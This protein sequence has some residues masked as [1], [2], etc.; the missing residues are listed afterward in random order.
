MKYSALS[1]VFLSL[2]T[3]TGCNNVGLKNSG[4]GPSVSERGSDTF[5]NLMAQ[6]VGS[7][8]PDIKVGSNL[9]LSGTPISSIKLDEASGA[10][11]W[12]AFDTSLSELV[13][14]GQDLV[15]ASLGL[16]AKYENE[17]GLTP[18]EI[19]VQNGAEQSPYKGVKLVSL[20]RK[21]QGVP[22]KGAFVNFFFAVQSDQTL[23][24]SE[25]V[26]NSY[27]PIKIS[28]EIPP[29]PSDSEVVEATGVDTLQVISKVPVI[30]PVLDKDGHYEFAY[31]TE[32]KLDDKSSAEKIT[33]TMDNAT[34]EIREA[35]SNHV[36]EVNQ[37][38][39][40]SFERSYAL[41]DLISRPLQF[42]QIRDG[43]SV[44]STDDKGNVTSNGSQVTVV[45]TNTKNKSSVFFANNLQTPVSFPVSLDPGGKSDIKF[46]TGDK[47]AFNV[48][49]AIQETFK[50]VAAQ[51]TPNELRI[52]ENGIGA[53][54]NLPD[55]CNAFYDGQ[56]LNFFSE[57]T[58]CGNTGLISDVIHHEWGHGLD[59]FL[60]T[61][62]RGTNGR[63]GITDGAYSEGIGDILSAYMANSP[64]LAPGFFLNSTQPLRVLTN[65]RTHPP[66]NANEAE[67][68]SAGLIVGGAFWDLHVNL[69]NLYGL[70]K[71]SEMANRLFLRHLITSD[72]YTD[73]YQAVLRVD[74]DDNNPATRSP[75]YCN[76]T[77]AFARHNITGGEQ[78]AA[79]CVDTD[80]SLKV[81][82]ELDQGEGLLSVVASALG[83]AKIV[84][85]PGKVTSCPA[86][87]ETVE[88]AAR[89]GDD[90]VTLKGNRKYY[91]GSGTVNAKASPT[92]SFFSI[93]AK[94]KIM[95]KRTLDFK[96]E[97]AAPVVVP[98][99]TPDAGVE[100]Q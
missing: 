52:I 41:K 83:A 63:S 68:H 86:S 10:W 17:L 21:Y 65:N 93:D 54:V 84:A 98:T 69:T 13:K 79:N 90:I 92:Y 34:K 73:A 72:R 74:D 67:I 24:L 33:M 78:V 7:L 40:E 87:A 99:V 61:S 53:A 39:A 85:C 25:I 91:A 66:V 32:F 88:F 75:S 23:R 46:G 57:S 1:L 26:N 42:T 18:A 59:D 76:I 100:I 14:P 45:L 80:L 64:N 28:T 36:N 19:L 12:V 70:V 6:G 56:R 60:G 43:N 11:A 48:F 16:V 89:E 97:T 47:A 50:F 2:Y 44:F 82:V 3:L 29:M 81:K 9:G 15:K 38:N 62:S 4:A 77:Q 35:F 22:I 58:R 31:A 37:I 49:V 27:G 5:K 95:A 55:A 8:R 94:G 96:P 71:G 20:Q 30:Q 51:L